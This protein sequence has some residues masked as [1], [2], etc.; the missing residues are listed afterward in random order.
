VIYQCHPDAQRTSAPFGDCYQAFCLDPLTNARLVENCP[1]LAA[2][3]NRYAL[4]EYA[5][6]LYFWRNPKNNPDD[7][8]GFTS[9]RQ[10]EKV[11]FVLERAHLEQLNHFDILTWGWLDVG[12]I[13]AQAETWHAGITEAATRTLGHFGIGMPREWHSGACG[14]FANYWAMRMTAFKEYMSWSWPL[15]SWMLKNPEGLTFLEKH[16]RHE[17]GVGYL[18]E[19]LFIVWYGGKRISVFDL[20]G[21]TEVRSG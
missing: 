15:V 14:V 2:E 21:N 9:H 10:M 5:A 19:R 12:N 13:R 7:W 8:I 16:P 20:V 18:M 4:S 1:E 3:E 11:R 17:N 6:M